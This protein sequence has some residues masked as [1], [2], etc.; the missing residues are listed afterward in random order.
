M[1][2]FDRVFSAVWYQFG[3]DGIAVNIKEN[4]EVIIDA[5]RWYDKSTCLISAYFSSDGLAINV[6]VISTQTCCFTFL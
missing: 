1:G 6:S 3:K 5:D 2:V 4:K